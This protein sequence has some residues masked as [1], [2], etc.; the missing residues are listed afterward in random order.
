MWSVVVVGRRSSCVTW[1]GVG[2]GYGMTWEHRVVM[3]GLEDGSGRV[4]A[5]EVEGG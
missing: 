4:V 5:G 2:A 3:M 1:C